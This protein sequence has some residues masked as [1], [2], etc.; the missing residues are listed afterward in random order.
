[1]K[2]SIAI[3]GVLAALGGLAWLGTRLTA[4]QPGAPAAAP[5]SKVAVVN[6]NRVIKGYQKANVLGQYLLNLGNYY[7][8]QRKAKQD[9]LAAKQQEAQKEADATKREALAA[10]LKQLAREI[11]DLEAQA[12]RDMQ[13]KQGEIAVQVYKEIEGVVAGVAHANDLELVLIYPDVTAP[14]EAGLPATVFRKLSAPAALPI[15]YVPQLD[16]TQAVID[17]LNR[18]FPAPQ[19]QPAP[20]GQQPAAG[21]PA[22][23]GP[24]PAAPAPGTPGGQPMQ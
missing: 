7:N 18:Q 15:Y 12:S 16:I 5:R 22:P 11:E 21:Q 17:T 3:L 1:V 20:A 19:A 2:R 10:Q 14:E 4:Q 8:Q 13:A 9:Q 6:I 23:A 24:Q